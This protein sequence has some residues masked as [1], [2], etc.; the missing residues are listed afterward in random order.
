ML[1]KEMLEKIAV[2]QFGGKE[3]H[4]V[5]YAIENE[6]A[7][8]TLN[9]I[10]ATIESEKL[11]FMDPAYY[12]DLE[13]KIK[14][15]TAI[16]ST[17]PTG[18]VRIDP[19]V[20]K[21]ER[22]LH[23]SDV[24]KTLVLSTQTYDAKSIRE[25]LENKFAV[26][27]ELQGLTK[28][29][30]MAKAKRKLKKYSKVDPTDGQA[31][32]TPEMFRAIHIRMGEWTDTKEEGYKLLDKEE[33]T[34][35]EQN[36]LDDL[37]MQP[38]KYVFYGPSKT[39]GVMAPVY[40]KMSL[41]TL[42]PRLVYKTQLQPL[43]DRMTDPNDPV[44]MIPFDSAVKVGR[45]LTY[46][47]YSE[48]AGGEVLTD[49]VDEGELAN[50]VSEPLSFKY[51]RKQVVTEPHNEIRTFVGTQFRKLILSNI[52]DS[53]TYHIDGKPVSGK[54]LKAEYAKLVADLSELGKEKLLDE[55][56]LDKATYREIAPN[57]TRQELMERA[58]TASMSEALIDA[59]SNQADGENYE[60]DSLPDRKWIQSTLLSLMNKRTVDLEL[61]G[62][63]LIQM[64]NFGLR[65]ATK[66]DS[67]QLMDKKG[68]MEAKVSVEIF[69]DVIPNYENISHEER[70]NFA[71]AMLVGVGYR[72]PTQG[73]NSIVPLKI[74]GFLPATSTA[75]ITL[76]SEFTA[77]TGSDFDIDKLYFVRHN[78]KVVEGKAVKI[79][80]K[81]GEQN[82][83]AAIENRLVDTYFGVLLSA[84][85][86]LQN[87][88]PLDASTDV[89]KGISDKV[90]ELEGL[91]KTM[92]SL[93]SA[94]FMY[95]SSVK[96]SY[97]WG[98]K[99]IAPFARAN[100]HHILGQIAGIHLNR[101]IGVGH[102]V[103]YQG[104]QVTDLSQITGVDGELIQDWLSALISA[105]VDIA[106]DP[107]IFALNVNAATYN[108]GELLI[109]AGVGSDTFWFLSQ[110]ILK[111][112]ALAYMDA[113][114]K[115]KSNWTAAMT[116]IQ[117]LYETEMKKAAGYE[118]GMTSNTDVWDKERLA[119][120]I[121]VS[122]KRNADFYARQ[123]QI[124]ATFND[125][126]TTG[127]AL[128]E[129]VN[130]V[131][132]D[133]KRYG[134]SLTDI[135]AFNKL[136]DKVL[137][138]NIIVNMD[139]VF[140][141][142]FLGKLYENSVVLGQT[143]FKDKD[144]LSSEGVIALHSNIMN[145]IGRRY[146]VTRK[147]TEYINQMSDEIYS[148]I[149]GTFMSNKLN[150][151]SEELK[152]MMFG[153]DSM[154]SRLNSIKNDP[155]YV[156]NALIRLLAPHMTF[157][158]GSPDFIITFSATD[159]KTKWAKDRI[160]E[161]WAELLLD[162]DPVI[163]AF[164]KDL[165]KYA[166]YTSG[167]KRTIYSIFNFIPPAYLK[168][169]GF[170]SYI[171]NM[172][173]KFNDVNNSVV[174]ASLH[175]DVFRHLWDD[176]LVVPF[177]SYTKTKDRRKP[178]EWENKYPLMIQ[179]K[180]DAIDD[181]FLGLNKDFQPVYKPFI[182]TEVSYATRLFKYIGYRVLDSGLISPVYAIDSPRGYYSAGKVIKEYGLD[183]SVIEENNTDS[184]TQ[185]QIDY[186]VN[187][188][189][190]HGLID[191]KIVY[192]YRNFTAVPTEN[193]QIELFRD[194][195]NVSEVEQIV[196][197]TPIAEETNETETASATP[198]TIYNKLGGKTVSENVKIV[199][200]PY[201]YSDEQRKGNAIVA[202]RSTKMPE[203]FE[204]PFHVRTDKTTKENVIDFIDFVLNSNEPQAVWIREKAKS[205][206]FKGKPIYYGNTKANKENQPSHATA[207]DYLINKHSWETQEE[208]PFKPDD[209]ATKFST[210]SPEVQAAVDAA[211]ITDFTIDKVDPKV[212]KELEE[213]Y[214][215]CR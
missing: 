41:A 206:E 187:H 169:I 110:P 24:F 181:L 55:L 102:T 148:A 147:S 47:Y 200:K 72:I 42:T 53:Q 131:Q 137:R 8:F 87:W 36:I 141:M 170:S 21:G 89:I 179:F 67:L 69:R 33:L 176:D 23:D 149:A 215:H 22:L 172:R 164:A 152:N 120:D 161:G 32:I 142:T 202:Y 134:N 19:K 159:S 129:A 192:D 182:K 52:V 133:T 168:E 125:L 70:L 145:E 190:L 62:T 188:Q 123:L 207:L 17:G 212:L 99:G 116:S 209:A 54:D 157:E 13:D 95:Q 151:S 74:V 97:L 48:G 112:Y 85:H 38:L 166:F 91:N 2:K 174:A 160:V 56:G 75:T 135:R 197:T 16:A 12:K 210:A 195:M 93:Y 201:L 78:Y 100:T 15:Y 107:Y 18:R 73:L 198:G 30:A 185:E 199:D 128:L 1:D 31:Y 27:Y 156:N 84:D 49:V 130:A 183:K 5:R 211:G 45:K 94:S 108:V 144:I 163:Q 26:I 118:E 6:I 58:R 104:R 61:P 173:V 146:D 82:S 66:D 126:K 7:N 9:S 37:F 92:P 90:R 114:G 158:E 3:Q 140:E 43:Y 153:E 60:Y 122:T 127:H 189:E 11:I 79:E 205:G 76:P 113:Q 115:I 40:Y 132:V 46:K 178:P 150:M 25:E 194:E 65:K 88:I 180:Q 171:K 80:Y 111:E 98:K 143:I 154:T 64:T 121:D 101:N 44:D 191:D 204:N 138:D 106:K 68:F 50:S 208:Y 77:L 186:L 28:E 81:E 35:A 124:L 14:R 4:H 83:K 96:D 136:V 119:N 39:P 10:M 162:T 184:V 63:A 203:S 51:L 155:K 71:N 213:K 177:I 29:A 57:K 34:A 167:F 86:A 165:V 103:E 139:K 109:R 105:H 196:G 20:M 117:N 214:S 59:L 175:D 193:M